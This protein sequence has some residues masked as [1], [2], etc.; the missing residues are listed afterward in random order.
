MFD[1]A[2]CARKDVTNH[3]DATHILSLLDPGVEIDDVS[4]FEGKERLRIDM[5]DIDSFDDHPTA[6]TIDQVRQIIDWSRTIPDDASLLVHCEAGIS[7]STAAMMV[8]L[9][10]QYNGDFEKANRKVRS[11]RYG[12]CPNLR[13]CFFGDVLLKANGL[14]DL[15]ES[16]HIDHGW[17]SA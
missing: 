14:Y 2:I 4:F 5:E 11:I 12:A 16:Y 6:P 7:R 1:V 3:T 13:I 9:T 15:A 17:I 10:D 8:I